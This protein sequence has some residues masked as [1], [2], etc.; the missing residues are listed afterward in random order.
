MAGGAT[1]YHYTN[2]RLTSTSGVEPFSFTYNLDGDV[3]NINGFTLQ[4]DRLHH[5]VSYRQGSNSIADF[6]YDGDGMR[7]TKTSGG[8]TTVYHYDK[9]GRVLSETEENGALIT[10]YIYLHGKLV[11]KVVNDTAP[12]AGSILVNA[13]AVY[14]HTAYVTL[15]LS[16]FDPQS[17]VSQMRFSND[18]VHWSDWE[19]YATS[20]QWTEA[21]QDQRGYGAQTSFGVAYDTESKKFIIFASG[22]TANQNED[23]VLGVNVGV[24]LTVG[25]IEGGLGDFLGESRE[26]S[27][28]FI[29]G[30][31]TDIE[32]STNKEGV[33]YSIGG[34]GLGL[35]YTSITTNTFDMTERT[36]EIIKKKQD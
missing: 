6:T 5:L 2:N 19:P 33:S 17:G 25:K 26:K 23:K 27:K 14:T 8:K 31:K 24:G 12:P 21:K 35:S 3:V 22:G 32:T 16:A 36:K 28:T 4:H 30:T 13:G 11:A 9:E 20:K 29:F 18:G 10:D 1:N 7:V 34:K 15:T